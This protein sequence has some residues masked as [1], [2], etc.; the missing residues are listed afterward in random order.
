MQY[1]LSILFSSLFLCQNLFAQSVPNDNSP[2]PELDKLVHHYVTNMMS[3]N[4]CVGVSIGLFSKGDLWKYHFGTSEIGKAS[5]PN[6]ETVYEIA[7]L[8]KTFTGAL[9]AKALSEN[10]ISLADDIRKTG[11]AICTVFN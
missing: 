6:D 7:S 10:R 8:T 2:N 5:L 11:S 9:L 3:E 1:P 4:S